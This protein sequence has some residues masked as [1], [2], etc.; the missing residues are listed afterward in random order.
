[1]ERKIYLGECDGYGNGRKICKA[2][3]KV[4]L[5][6]EGKGPKFAASA[7]IWN[8]ERANADI[9]QGGQCVDTVAAMFP[10]NAEAQEVVRLWKRWHLNDMKAG[11]EHQRAEKWNERPIDESKPHDVYVTFKAGE[12]GCL[13][14]YSGWNMLA[15]IRRNEHPK[16]LLCEPCPTCGYKYGSEWLYEPIAPDDLA[17]MQKIVAGK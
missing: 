11:C 4:R 15:W 5:D 14:D 7:E 12:S 6:D 8:A 9:I 3:L 10:E 1:M 17:S 13:K 16:S 2:F